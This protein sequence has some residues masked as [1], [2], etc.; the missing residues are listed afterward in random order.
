MSPHQRYIALGNDREDDLAELGAMYDG[1]VF[2]EVV[3]K[4]A[5]ECRQKCTRPFDTQHIVMC[6]LNAE[7]I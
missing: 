2:A 5:Y 7:Q 3:A 4:D 6:K 1:A